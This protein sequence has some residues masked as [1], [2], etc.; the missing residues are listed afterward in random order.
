MTAITNR[1][2]RSTSRI[3]SH[4]VSSLNLVNM[5][6]VYRATN[7]GITSVPTQETGSTP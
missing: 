1:A 3:T 6:S 7:A 5:R 2:M 4:V